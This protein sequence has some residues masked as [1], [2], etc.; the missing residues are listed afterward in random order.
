MSSNDKTLWELHSDVIRCAEE[1]RT[2]DEE[3]A[4]V[5]A[6]L[7]AQLAVLNRKKN[8]ARMRYLRAKERHDTKQALDTAAA[9][10]EFAAMFN[11]HKQG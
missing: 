11:P 6:E 4:R 7:S 1:I 10:A 8:A 5:R 2:L 3:H 9:Q